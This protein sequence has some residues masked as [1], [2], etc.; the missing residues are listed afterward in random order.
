MQAF[1]SSLLA[2]LLILSASGEATAKCAD[3]RGCFPDICRYPGNVIHLTVLVPST[4]EELFFRGRV[5]HVHIV[6]A[7]TFATPAVGD[8]LELARWNNQEYQSGQRLIALSRPPPNVAW[9][10]FALSDDGSVACI[11]PGMTTPISLTESEFVEVA[12]SQRCD[13]PPI[14]RLPDCDDD[15]NG[16]QGGLLHPSIAALALLVVLR[17]LHRP[18]RA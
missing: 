16:C 1:A 12:E 4:R 6:D 3:P 18:F 14:P 9:P 11:A 5:D 2:L 8:E 13:R 15:S 10:I 7:E 17:G